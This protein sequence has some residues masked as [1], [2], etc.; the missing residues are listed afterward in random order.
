MEGKTSFVMYTKYASQI[1]KLSIE[2]RG[3]LFTAIYA[4]ETGEELPQL[5]P[6]TDMLFSIMAE[7][8]DHDNEK[9]QEAKKAR[10]AAGS[11]G[12]TAKAEK[13]KA[14]KPSNPSNATEDVAKPSNPSNATNDVANVADYVSVYDSVSV[15]EKERKKEKESRVVKP[16]KRFED[17]WE[18]YPKYKK[19]TDVSKRHTEHAYA[20]CMMAG[21]EE[22]NLV[23]AAKNYAEEIRIE[24]E[25]EFVMFAENFLAKNKFF[26]YL[27]GVYVKPKPKGKNAFTEHMH[28]EY[29]FAELEELVSN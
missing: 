22:D 14:A 12:G 3:M 4:Y 23:A 5:D 9:W 21:V 10:A 6:I 11:K 19:K 26:D 27:P 13:Q 16:E 8:F 28:T 18:A 25:Q 15:L 2:Q 24:G 17:F 20:N 7:E 29:N 1:A